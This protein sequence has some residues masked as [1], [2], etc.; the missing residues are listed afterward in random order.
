M[1][2]HLRGRLLS[3]DPDRVVV[4]TGAGLGYEV[5][6]APRV[7]TELPPIGVEVALHVHTQVAETAITL[8]GFLRDE[9]KRLF[10]AVQTVSGIGP[11]LA[12]AIVGT[13]E[14]RALAEAVAREDIAGLIKIPGLGKK[15]AARLCIDLKDKLDRFLVPEGLGSTAVL[16]SSSERTFGPTSVNLIVTLRLLHSD[17]HIDD[18]NLINS[19][20]I[21]GFR[22]RLRARRCCAGAP[23]PRRCSRRSLPVLRC[24][25]S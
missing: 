9:D 13:T 22:R 17:I 8:Y 4:E 12:L 2:G 18:R 15:T 23:S 6:V 20:R 24:F 14:P 19:I 25:G 11:K 7:L 3:Q 1:I 21:S 16:A 10:R 5:L